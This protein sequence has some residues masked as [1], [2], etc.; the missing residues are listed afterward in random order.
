MATIFVLL[1]P[2][3][4]LAWVLTCVLGLED[5]DDEDLD[6]EDLE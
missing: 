1:G 3:G 6:E 4:V 5:D 2:L